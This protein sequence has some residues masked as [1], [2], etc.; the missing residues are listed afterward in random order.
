MVHKW[1]IN[2]CGVQEASDSTC[3]LAITVTNG[4]P[5]F[6]IG[7]PWPYF[8]GGELSDPKSI[9]KSVYLGRHAP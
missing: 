3:N 5:V 2:I 8:N 4:H 6:V 9:K 7:I 1:K